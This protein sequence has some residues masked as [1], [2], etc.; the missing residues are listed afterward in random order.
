MRLLATHLAALRFLRTAIPRWVRCFAPDPREPR[1][2]A[3]SW[4]PGVSRRAFWG[5]GA[6][7]LTRS[8]GILLC[9]CPALRPRQ[10]PRTRPYS[11]RTRP[12]LQGT[13][14]AHCIANFEAL[15]HGFGT[16]CLRLVRI[17]QPLPHRSHLAPRKTRFRL[18]ASSTGRD[19]LP[20]G[21]QRKV[22]EYVSL[23]VHPPLPS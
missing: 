12:P 9:S 8:W 23:H 17:V 19:W 16:R 5:V 14:K 10:D 20:V 3:R 6:P 15:S 13:A 11:P 2:R 7:G 1:S 21:F 18:P 4:S 22:S